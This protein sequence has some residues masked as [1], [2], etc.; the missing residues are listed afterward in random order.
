MDGGGEYRRVRNYAKSGGSDGLKHDF[1]A[2]PGKEMPT[3]DPDRRMKE[4]PNG[5]RIV[6]RTRSEEGSPTLEVQPK[7]ASRGNNIRVKIRYK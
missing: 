6:A 7:D 3:N 4:L 1:E 5:D 2:A